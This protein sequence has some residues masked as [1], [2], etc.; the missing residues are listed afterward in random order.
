MRSLLKEDKETILFSL[1]SLA[2]SSSSLS[3]FSNANDWDFGDTSQRE[4]LGNNPP[5]QEIAIL[6]SFWNFPPRSRLKTLPKLMI[7]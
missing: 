7:F 6:I 3:V 1:L 5:L 2:W 4:I